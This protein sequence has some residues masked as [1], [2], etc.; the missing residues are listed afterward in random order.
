[1]TKLYLFLLNEIYR[2]L[3]NPKAS[4]RA[5]KHNLLMHLLHPLFGRTEWYK[6][7]FWYDYGVLRRPKKSA[8]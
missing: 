3:L 5:A 8:R 2:F 4:L 1:M 6:R 7:R